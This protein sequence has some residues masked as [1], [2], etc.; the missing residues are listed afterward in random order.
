MKFIFFSIAHIPGKLNNAAHFL[1]RLKVD[2]NE[3]K[4]S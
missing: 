4:G 2:P 3:K 1:S